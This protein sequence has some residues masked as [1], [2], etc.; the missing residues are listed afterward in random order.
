MFFDTQVNIHI[1]NTFIPT[2]FGRNIYNRQV[3]L[4]FMPPSTTQLSMTFL[5]K[6]FNLCKLQ[7]PI[8]YGVSLYKCN[9]ASDN[10]IKHNFNTR[11][12]IMDR[13]YYSF[14]SL[15]CA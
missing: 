8:Y 6:F 4:Y 1:V 14:S 3:L 11:Q 2:S 10:F 7:A 9:L 15:Y 12:S 5:F 13:Y